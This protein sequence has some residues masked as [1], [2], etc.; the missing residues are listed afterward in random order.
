MAGEMT[1]TAAAVGLQG[2]ALRFPSEPLTAPAWSQL[3]SEAQFHRVVGLLAAAVHEGQLAAG[4]DQVEEVRRAHAAAME[5]CLSLD[6]DLLSAATILDDAGV[7]H[8]VLKGSAFAHLD[9]PDPSLRVY[10]DVDLLVR[11]QRF[12]DAVAAL[13]EAAYERRYQQVRAGFDRRFGK[14]AS[15]TGSAHRGLDLHRTFVMARTGCPSSSTMSGRPP[16]SSSSQDD[17]S[18]PSTPRGASSTLASMPRWGTPRLAWSR[19]VTWPACSSGPPT[20]SVSTGS[21][22]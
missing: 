21:V 13:T 19:S 5:V 20:H 16:P 18:R 11:S 17:V 9:Y 15:F 3:L 22:G 6:A 14:G 12:D 2:S 7:E 1:R 4:P 8:R 10:A